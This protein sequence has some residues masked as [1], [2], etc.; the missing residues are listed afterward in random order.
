MTSRAGTDDT[1]DPDQYER[2]RDER[3]R[4][5]LDLL[6]MVRPVPGGRAVDLGCGTGELTRWLHR[7]VGAAETLGIDSS[8]VMLERAAH[9]R[10]RLNG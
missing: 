10:I 1:W 7:H 2:F 9:S 8:P 3:T 5:F 6:A 4:P